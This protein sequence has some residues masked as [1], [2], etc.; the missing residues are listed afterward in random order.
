MVDKIACEEMARSFNQQESIPVY[1]GFPDN[2]RLCKYYLDFTS[3]GTVLNI[4][5]KDD[6]LWVK[7]DFNEAGETMLLANEKPCCAANWFVRINVANIGKPYKL[8]S[9]GFTNPVHPIR[10]V[11]SSEEYCYPQK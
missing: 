11:L 2:P 7:V 1:N 8:K 10:K 5:P 3:H 9:I 4:L 6:S